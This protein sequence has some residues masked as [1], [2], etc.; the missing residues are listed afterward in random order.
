MTITALSEQLA[1]A[2]LDSVVMQKLES[3]LE[4][5]RHPSLRVDLWRA[6]NAYFRLFHR[7]FADLEK[8]SEAGDAD[9]GAQADRFARIGHLLSVRV[10]RKQ[11]ASARQG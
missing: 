9:A 2:P 8:K 5:A 6:Q 7:I 1:E 3:A 11:Y 10:S 4:V